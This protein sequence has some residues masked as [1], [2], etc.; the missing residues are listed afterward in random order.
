MLNT[1]APSRLSIFNSGDLGALFQPTPP[2]SPSAVSRV[3]P[4][5]PPACF[6]CVS[7]R[8]ATALLH[9]AANSCAV[10][11]PEGAVVIGFVAGFVY[12]ASSALLLKF[13]VCLHR[14]TLTHAHAHTHICTTVLAA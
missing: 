7:V 11:M 14:V 13:E 5:G 9:S 6:V 10:V 3:T 12:N 8:A 1:Q 2:L 4:Y